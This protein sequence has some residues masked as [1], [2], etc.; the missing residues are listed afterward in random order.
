MYTESTRYSF[1]ARD[2][3]I[4]VCGELFLTR[5]LSLNSATRSTAL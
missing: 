2:S 1:T 5:T 4:L 3:I